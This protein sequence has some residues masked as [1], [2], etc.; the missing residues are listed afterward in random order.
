MSLSR[1]EGPAR[2]ARPISSVRP[3]ADPAATPPRGQRP[4]RE[5]A[6]DVSEA[7]WPPLV[8]PRLS[9]VEKVW[10]WSPRP[11]AAFLVPKNPGSSDS[12]GQRPDLGWQDRTFQTQSFWQPG[13]SRAAGCS[14]AL[15]S[16]GLGLQG[17][18]ALGVRCGDPAEASHFPPHTSRP[19][20]QTVKREPEELPVRGKET[21]LKGKNSVRQPANPILDATFSEETKPA[22]CDIK[23]KCK[24]DSVITSEKKENNTSSSSLKIPQIQNQAPL[25]S[26]K[27]SYFRDNIT[28]ISPEFPRD[29][30]SN[31]SFVY[32]KE[33][34][35]K[36]N[37]KIVAYVRDFTNIFWSQNKP[38]AK[39][40]KLQDDKKNVLMENGFPD[41]ESQHQSLTVEGK[42]DLINLNYDYHSSI[43][44]DVRYSEKNFTL[45]LD[46]ANWEGT[47]SNLDCYIPTRQQ[48]SQRSDYNR[49]ILKRKRCNC[50]IIKKYR[51]ICEA[52]KKLGGDLDLAQLL[53]TDLLNKG[54]NH[55][56]K[57]RNV[58][59]EQ[60]KTL[61]IGT[62][63]TLPDLIKVV[64]FNGKGKNAKILQL[65][66]YTAQKYISGN[67]D[68]S[69]VTCH[70]KLAYEKQINIQ[71]SDILSKFSQSNFDSFV[72]NGDDWESELECI[73]KCTVH[74][75]CLKSIIKE[76]HNV[77]L[78][79]MFI[80]SRPLENNTKF[81][82]KRRKLVKMEHFLEGPKRHNIGSLT[83]AT[84]RFPVYKPHEHVP[85]LMDF[86]DMEGLSLT[87]EPSYENTSCPERLPNVGNWA[88]YSFSIAST[89][90]KSDTLFIQ[91]NCG[92]ISE[93]CYE[94]GMYNQDLDIERKQKHKAPHFKFI[95]EDVFNVRQ[96]G[97]LLSQ[98]TTHSDQMSAMAITQSLSM[99]NLGEIEWKMYGFIVNKDVKV[100]ESSSSCQAHKAIESEKEEDSSPP[101]SR[102]SSVHLA[103]RVNKNGNV[104]ETQSANQNKGTNTQ[105][106]GGIL[107][108]SKLVHSKH[109]HP[110]S[111]L[112]ADHQF[113]SDSSGENNGC[114]QSLTAKCLSTET[115]PTAKDFEMKSKFDL[116]LEEL[117][118]FHEISKEDEIPRTPETNNRKENYFE[119]SDVKEAR[120]EVEKDL[121]M[122]EINE[123][124]A[125]SL[126]CDMKAVPKQHKNHQGLFNWKPIPTHGG[127]A[128]PNE[129]CVRSEEEFLHSTPE[130]DYK[131][132]F[133]K[134][135][136][137]SP[138]E[139]KKENYNYLLK[140]GSHFSHGI[141][142]IQPLKTCS[143]PIRVG[144]SRRAS[145][146]QLHP[147]L[148]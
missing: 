4:R 103:S 12:G 122:V 73:F 25:E 115:L 37:D 56:A 116:V 139:Y 39:K 22:L 135:P 26:A 6:A 111:T 81:M 70:Q 87:K 118:M 35:K 140:G 136:A 74:L 78:A 112:Y 95:F 31:M 79:R 100:L 92:H 54:D 16:C 94:S 144:L 97:T 67:K 65:R 98:N 42:I 28:I 137:F 57:V 59:E 102:V 15:R 23:D 52:I 129:Y 51:I 27:P 143:R 125:P 44:C 120:M 99:E 9:E 43:E 58:Q 64:W 121:E 138:D 11:L 123:R 2:P 133:L 14:R 91:N 50:W 30:N 80:S 89:D 126:P 38:D 69:T 110:D 113:E 128:V 117:R 55:N 18:E 34:A 124:K 105:K 88:C 127:Q 96:L 85:L 145:L 142:R 131:N 45:T 3:P 90:V 86:D 61:T 46:D 119:E 8:V 148:K 76:N 114:L 10:E 5:E 130:E 63:G 84:K 83:V 21:F 19:D 93:K 7:G 66:Y 1:P 77:D 71:K 108:E 101:I 29:L 107:Q 32:L 146:K 49:A 104:G 36:E 60:P 147:Y 17:R 141:S 48:E 72:T 24:A 13:T 20:V 47:E 53:E 68:N 82:A 132:S 40:Q 41:D 33:I 75:N 109:L 62:L 134:R 106:D